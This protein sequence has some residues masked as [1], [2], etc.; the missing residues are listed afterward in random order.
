MIKS[1]LS[2]K[3]SEY[4]WFA[5]IGMLCLFLVYVYLY[6]P[7]LPTINSSQNSS[8]DYEFE[9]ITISQFYDGEQEW[10]MMAQKGRLY[11]DNPLIFLEGAQGDWIQDNVQIK[12]R[13]NKSKI[14]MESAEFE[15]FESISTIQV[16]NG[17]LWTFSS[18]H[19]FINL[20]DYIFN[21]LKNNRLYSDLGVFRGDKLNYDM[22]NEKISIQQNANVVMY[23]YQG[24]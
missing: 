16:D 23:G 24:D 8:P 5:G 12:F 18:D 2:H 19:L 1:P 22:Q 15:L 13:A 9:N 20:N 17:R 6:S 10:E 7:S 3:L 11:Q 14:L 4:S 21:G